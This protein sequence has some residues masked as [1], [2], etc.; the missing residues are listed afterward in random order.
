MNRYRKYVSAPTKKW[1]FKRD[2][3][4]LDKQW[5]S[6]RGLKPTLLAAVCYPDVG[7]PQLR[8]C[9][10]FLAYLFF[11]DNSSDEL[12]N[13]DTISVADLV[14]NSFYHPLNYQ[15]TVRIAAMSK[16]FVYNLSQNSD[17]D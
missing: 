13:H 6:F 7:Y 9:S 14:L 15:S 12:D 10:D 8:L 2:N 11:L 17:T 5:E 4:L 3:I 1:F 16:E